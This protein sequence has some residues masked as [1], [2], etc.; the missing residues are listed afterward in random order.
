MRFVRIESMKLRQEK[1]NYTDGWE[2]LVDC[3]IRYISASR[4][5]D[6]DFCDLHYHEYIELLYGI[7]G[8]ATVMI[9]E[10]LY[11]MGVGDLVIV[12]AR[13]AHS[14]ACKSGEAKYYVIKFLP[15]LLYAQ[16]HSLSAVRYLFPLWQK[17]AAF[18]P[19]VS[20][21]ELQ[22]SRVDELINEIMREWRH[23]SEGYE[24]VMQANIMQIFVWTVRHCC[25]VREERGTLPEALQK[26]LQAALEE[27]HK[28]LEDW[29]ARDAAQAC[30]LSY[31]YFSR[32]FKLAFGISFSAYLE[33]VRLREGERLLLTTDREITDIAAA[34][35]FGSTS[36]F[37][38]RFRI[39]YGL[40]PRVFRMQM[41]KQGR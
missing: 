8:N 31:S 20:K 11:P 9:G 3:M 21:K 5:Q 25:P 4:P 40:S 12:N 36:Y 33:S 15:K 16:G 41:R 1:I 39:R 22:G 35:G 29:T 14:V 7:E 13:E 23:K 18:S 28:H 34:V 10:H 6:T 24:L 2:R 38:E 17:E 32:N 30:N 37:I 27:T 19:V 26:S